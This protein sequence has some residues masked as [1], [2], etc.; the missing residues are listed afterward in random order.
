[1]DQ[2][3]RFQLAALPLR[4]FL[5]SE[6]QSEIEGYQQNR[7]F[8]DHDDAMPNVPFRRMIRSTSRHSRYQR[9]LHDILTRQTFRDHPGDLL[10]NCRA[11]SE[12]QNFFREGECG[13]ESQDILAYE[14][15]NLEL[16]DYMSNTVMNPYQIACEI[17][18]E[19]TG[20]DKNV[21]I[22]GV[23]EE[24]EGKRGHKENFQFSGSSG[25][26]KF[27]WQP[28]ESSSLYNQPLY[29]MSKKKKKSRACPEKPL[30]A[31]GSALTGIAYMNSDSNP[32][33]LP[34]CYFA[35]TVQPS[36]YMNTA[37]Y[38]EGSSKEVIEEDNWKGKQ[39]LQKRE[40]PKA[41]DTNVPDLKSSVNPIH[42]A[43]P[44]NVRLPKEP[45]QHRRSLSKIYNRPELSQPQS[46]E[47]PPGRIT[48]SRLQISNNSENSPSTSSEVNRNNNEY[49]VNSSML[50]PESNM[51]LGRKG[52]IRGLAFKRA[53]GMQTNFKLPSDIFV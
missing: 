41:A 42:N 30:P 50:S 9:Q 8:Y 31:V 10:S 7:R 51:T 45:V 38:Q 26:L 35:C 22:E 11:A 46:Q 36:F 19:H 25:P 6:I 1:M 34:S 33:D 24:Q 28:Y 48:L 15:E 20:N 3:R 37:S 18:Q 32:G 52:V 17:C 16:S 23:S 2:E 40:T 13:S 53:S 5:Q 21:D 43:V 27:S 49:L 14:L 4:Q 29:S 12:Y 44:K 47:S 39:P